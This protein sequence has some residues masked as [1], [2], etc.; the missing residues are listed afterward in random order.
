MSLHQD[1]AV[2][3]STLRTRTCNQQ[4]HGQSQMDKQEETTLPPLRQRLQRRACAKR[5]P[6]SLHQEP[7]AMQQPATLYLRQQTQTSMVNPS[8]DLPI[9]KG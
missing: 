8:K 5:Q 7:T 1:P 9:R 6:E 2:S 4:T 3:Q